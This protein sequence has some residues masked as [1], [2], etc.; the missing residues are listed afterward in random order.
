MTMQTA[1]PLKSQ[2]LNAT[3]RAAEAFRVHADGILLDPPYQR[4]PVWTVEQR[5][6]LVKSWLMGLPIPAIILNDRS[7]PGWAQANPNDDLVHYYAVIDGK[8]RIMTWLAWTEGDFAVPASWFNP[9]WVDR[10]EDTDDG[11][12]TRYPWLT[13]TGQRTMKNRAQMPTAEAKLA[14]VQEEAEVYLLVNGAGTPQTDA[15]L[16]RALAVAAS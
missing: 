7:N 2:S 11:P 1:G 10:T 9:E 16:A 13:P 6:G 4:G 5:R 15:D 8:Q 12:Y 3:N 14:T